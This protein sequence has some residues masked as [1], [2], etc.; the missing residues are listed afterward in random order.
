MC[1]EFWENVDRTSYITKRWKFVDWATAIL[2]RKNMLHEIS[3]EYL[4]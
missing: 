3:K 1:V 2:S 4:I